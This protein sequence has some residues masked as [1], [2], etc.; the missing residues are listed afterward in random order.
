MQRRFIITRGVIDMATSAILSNEGYYHEGALAL[1]DAVDGDKVKAAVDLALDKH[2]KKVQEVLTQH[3]TEIKQYGAA[4]DGTKTAIAKLNEDGGKIIGDFKDYQA[5]SDA[6]ILDLEQKLTEQRTRGPV[7]QK[8]LGE[9]FVESDEFKSA[10]PTLRSIGKQSMRPFQVKTITSGPA[11]AGT[12]IV[13]EYLPTPI[14]PPLQNLTIRDLL[15][16][17]TTETDQILWTQEDVF[18]NAAAVVSEGATKPNSNITYKRLNTNVQTI[19]HWIKASKQVLADFKQL[20]TLINGR[21]QFGLKLAEETEILFGSG[22]GDHLL[23]L[24]P[25]A[26]AYATGFNKTNDTEIDVI[27]HAILQVRLAFFPATGVVLSPVDWH[28][29]ELTKDAQL[30][31]IL[32]QPF[33]NIPAMI[34]GL[35]V[36]Q[37][38]SM[39]VGDFLVGAFKLAA[40][41]LDREQASIL[42]STEDQ[43]NFV[44]NL[45]TILCEERIA[46]AVTRPKAFV[47]GAFPSGSSS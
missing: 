40:T 1:A 7:K 4:Q 11:S 38:D 46:L 24:I 8:S 33:G 15:D 13:P 6:R 37:S 28:D 16:V 26:T 17:G 2:F 29:I 9:Q 30:R 31:Y 23:G 5:K 36:V 21:L 3:E 20:A 42:V 43:D 45:V 12:G 35:P 39:A 14:I 19:A 34:W 32:A 18:T 22:Q 27:R 25:Q 47:F 44:R 41:L 10:L